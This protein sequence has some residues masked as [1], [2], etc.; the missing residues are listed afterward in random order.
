MTIRGHD[1]VVEDV[2]ALRHGGCNQ[3]LSC[4]IISDGW[5]CHTVRVVVREENSRGIDDL[6]PSQDAADGQPGVIGAPEAVDLVV[7]GSATSSVVED[8]QDLDGFLSQVSAKLS[9]GVGCERTR[10]WWRRHAQG[11]CMKYTNVI[12][13]TWDPRCRSAGTGCRH[14]LSLIHI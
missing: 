3:V 1:Q 4:S 5:V 2:D 12:T 10:V 13:G 9:D 6:C 14:I 7:G 11:R 8:L